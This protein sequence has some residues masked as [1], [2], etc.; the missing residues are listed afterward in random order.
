[1]GRRVTAEEAFAKEQHLYEIF[2]P[3]GASFSNLTQGYLKNAPLAS[4]GIISPERLA[5][6]ESAFSKDD[7]TGHAAKTE[8]FVRAIDAAGQYG[9]DRVA[10]AQDFETRKMDVQQLDGRFE[11]ADQ[12]IGDSLSEIPGKQPGKSALDELAENA[13]K[14][15]RKAME[16]DPDKRY[17]SVA[18]LAEDLRRFRAGEPIVARPVGSVERTWRWCRRN[19]VL[20]GSLGMRAQGVAAALLPDRLKAAAHRQMAKPGPSSR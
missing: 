19:P 13:V 8:E 18:A 3:G 15:L 10:V 16:K 2:Q 6:V 14:L 9:T 17:E 1:M 12:A 7:A 11:R 4:A 20:A 5:A